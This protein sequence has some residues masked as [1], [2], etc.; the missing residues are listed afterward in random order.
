MQEAF[1][2][3]LCARVEALKVGPAS[4]PAAQIGSMIKVRAVE[5]S[6]A[7]C[8][9]P[10]RAARS[11]TQAGGRRH[12][13]H[14]LQSA[15]QPLAPDGQRPGHAGRASRHPREHHCLERLP[16]PETVQRRIGLL[17]G[18]AHTYLSGG[19]DA[20]G[21]ATPAG[22]RKPYHRS[23][24][25]TPFGTACVAVPDSRFVAVSVST[26]GR[27]RRQH[28]LPTTMKKR[29]GGRIFL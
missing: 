8:Q 5:K 3:R 9:T 12:S 7:M 10:W 2:Q 29:P 18:A 28:S 11:F 17:R 19:G 16:P 20:V 25:Y 1:A 23:T 22:S 14:H 13:P 6:N 21:G 24:S 27:T 26:T 15:G 4:D